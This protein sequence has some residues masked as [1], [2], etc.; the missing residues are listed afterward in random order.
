MV[1]HRIA[2]DCRFLSFVSVQKPISFLLAR[3]ASTTPAATTAAAAVAAP[4]TNNNLYIRPVRPELPGAVRL[5]FIPE[6]WCVHIRNIDKIKKIK[7]Y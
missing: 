6:E 4:G 7:I 2:S 5:G 1:F 3:T